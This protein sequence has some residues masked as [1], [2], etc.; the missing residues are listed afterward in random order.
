MKRLFLAVALALS[1]SL[2]ASGVCAKKY[3]YENMVFVGNTDG[4]ITTVNMTDF[5]V[6]KTELSDDGI[7]NRI[8]YKLTYADM[9]ID[10]KMTV[11]CFGEDGTLLGVQPFDPCAEYMDVPALT[12]SFELSPENPYID[13]SYVYSKKVEVY[14]LDGR[15]LE[16]SPLLLPVYE[17]VGWQK[18]VTL[19]SLDG[20]TIQVAPF[21]V[22][23]YESVGWYTYT[24]YIFNAQVKPA[25][26]NNKA[27]KSHFANLKL[28]SD[29]LPM[30]YGT[31]HEASLYAIRTETMDLWRAE[32]G[33]PI[34]YNGCRFRKDENGRTLVD[35]A[36][37]N[38]DYKK[39]LSFKVEFDICD[40][41]GKE[42]GEN[43]AYY[44]VTTA[45]IEP[46]ET[47][48]FTWVNATAENPARLSGFRVTEL[49]YE[50]RTKW[51]A[52]KE[53][54]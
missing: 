35:V 15:T 18:P 45:N 31:E 19:Y 16:V 11:S 12:A 53:E 37:T 23:A 5:E 47:L 6:L 28:V 13:N 54:Q 17:S 8:Y 48:M 1:V 30:F 7:T 26:E 44:Y 10:T 51:Y 14:S 39:I 4:R 32:A 41:S 43:Y 25:Y 24:D 42:I 22:S 20:R 38:V 29:Y 52:E 49:V 9:D 21:D 40:A 46:A 3:T 33:A 50:D 2:L 27:N 36:L 34:A